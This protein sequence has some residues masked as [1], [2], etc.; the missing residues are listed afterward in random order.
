MPPTLPAGKPCIGVV[1]A[2]LVVTGRDFGIHP[3]V[4]PLNDGQAMSPGITA[5]RLPRRQGHNPVDHCLTYFQDVMLP[6]SALLGKVKP[7]SKA[8]FLGAIFRINVGTLALSLEPAAAMHQYAIIGLRY[9]QRRKVTGHD[10]R[11]SSILGFR[12]QQLP[13]Y[14][15]LAQAHVLTAF[16][17]W[18]TQAFTRERDPRVRHSIATTF[19][20]LSLKLSQA[21]NLAVSDRCGAQGLASYNRMAG[22]HNDFRGISIAEGDTLVL[23][24]RLASE[25]IIGRYD[26]PLSSNPNSLLARHE[27]SLIHEA[28]QRLGSMRS[29]RS[30][31]FNRHILPTCLQIV[32][33]MGS[34]FAFDAAVEQRVDPRLIDMFVASM[35]SQ[36]SAW[37]AEVASLS[38]ATQAEM[39]DTAILA[40]EENL[41]EFIRESESDATVLAPIVSDEKWNAFRDAQPVMTTPHPQI[42]GQERQSDR[43]SSFV[44]SIGY[45]MM[46]MMANL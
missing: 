5:R 27:S 28:R 6:P 2:R 10:G 15:T 43:I 16:D 22:H 3:F 1:W 14:A 33:A 45:G 11:P 24:I 40:L 37:Y 25:I 19:K 29:H 13:M 36:D 30:D 18:A 41:E 34:R 20:A 8:G 31:E 38:R 12:T 32:E 44:K 26:V 21:A 42:V 17:K 4:V 35:M 39:L 7:Q 9:S 23:S 46:M